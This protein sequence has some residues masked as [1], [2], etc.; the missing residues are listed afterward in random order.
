MKTLYD[1]KL[2]RDAERK[3]RVANMAAIQKQIDEDRELLEVIPGGGP[4]GNERK[5]CCWAAP[6]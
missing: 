6:R 4:V 2:E 1:R 3:T 5:I